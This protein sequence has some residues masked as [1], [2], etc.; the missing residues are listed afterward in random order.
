VF[1]AKRHAMRIPKNMLTAAAAALFAAPIMC[2][3]AA[4]ELRR[5]AEVR[6]ERALDGDTLALAGGRVLRL[7]GVLAPKAADRG[8]AR[9][10]ADAVAAARA[11]LDRLA[12]GKTLALWHGDL[13]EDRHGRILAYARTEDGL[14]LQDELL[15]LGQARVFTQ[16]GGAERAAAMLALEAEARQARRGL[17]SL[18]AYAV[19]GDEEAGRFVD[20]FQIVEGRVL[21]A[22][23][24]REVFYL[25]FGRDFR[26]DFTIGLDR[27][28][29]R[30]FR[31]TGRDAA[32][33]QGK[34]I[35]VRGW[36][37]WRNG[38]YIGATH[39]EQVEVID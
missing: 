14:W 24:A 16:A 11:A 31:R 4:G 38:P 2:G 10:I 23:P 6:A 27:A 19:R 17:W 13:A 18:A 37:L 35:R 1:V 21:K 28:A 34:R 33:L 36:L 30:A 32:T 7:V 15:R 8:G 9:D 20:S 29:L 22:A 39:P 3:P 12:R 26:R 25:N 5:G